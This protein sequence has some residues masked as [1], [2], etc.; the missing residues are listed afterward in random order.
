MN[1]YIFI[2]KVLL[3]FAFK[4]YIR[5]HSLSTALYYT[6]YLRFCAKR[7]TLEHVILIPDNDWVKRMSRIGNCGRLTSNGG[8]FYIFIFSLK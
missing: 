7:V 1:I 5:Y 8:S 2:F 4:T 3:P 6:F